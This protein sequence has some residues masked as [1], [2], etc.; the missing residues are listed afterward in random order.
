MLGNEREIDGWPTLLL[1]RYTLRRLHVIE[2][3]NSCDQVTNDRRSK[4]V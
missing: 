1:K 3:Q 2:N 4:R